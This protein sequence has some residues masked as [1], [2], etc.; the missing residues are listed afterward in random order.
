MT[1]DTPTMTTFYDKRPACREES[2]YANLHCK[3]HDARSANR[4]T[5]SIFHFD[6]MLSRFKQ[7]RSTKRF[8]HA[9]KNELLCSMPVV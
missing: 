8:V 3:V 1:I 4:I 7:T 5:P 6:D 2:V 9:R